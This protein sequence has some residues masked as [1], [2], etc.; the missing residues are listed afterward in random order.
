MATPYKG[1]IAMKYIWNED[2]TQLLACNDGQRALERAVQG[3]FVQ[4]QMLSYHAEQ[5]PA[6]LESQSLLADTLLSVKALIPATALMT[7]SSYEG[8]LALQVA[9]TVLEAE[10]EGLAQACAAQGSS[11]ACTK[12]CTGCCYQLVLCT[13]QEVAL[14]LAYMQ[15]HTSCREHFL[16]QYPAWHAEAKD[17]SQSYLQWGKAFYGEGKDDASHSREDYYIPCPFLDA[18]GACVI[19][20]VRPYACRSSVAVDARCAAPDAQGKKGMH[21]ML[22]SFY[23]GHDGA[24]RALF[25][26]LY[27]QDMTLNIMPQV[28][29]EALA[30]GVA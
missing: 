16:Q 12:G 28:L 25:A 30:E 26:S 7:A 11:L 4:A 13:P 2:A 27:G 24:R 23:T 3:Y 15:E 1:E 21:N 20:A 5:T 10:G 9:N 29:Y 8:L 14:I 19:Y 6:F 22:F 17:I 18:A